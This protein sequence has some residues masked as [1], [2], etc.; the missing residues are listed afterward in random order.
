MRY[1]FGDYTFDAEQYELCRAGQLIP[2]EPRVFTLLAY[3]LQHAGRIVLTEEL[4]TQL[5]PQEFAPVE[6]L[7]NAVA[8]ARR[9]CR[10]RG[11]PSATSRPCGAG[12]IASSPQCTHGAV[13]TW[14]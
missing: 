11:R 8:Q 3:L 1:V 9:S 7:T 6:R 12:A 13:R 10:T 5:Y 14:S 4:L 2:V